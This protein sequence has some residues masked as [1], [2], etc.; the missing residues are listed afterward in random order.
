LMTMHPRTGE[1]SAKSASRTTVWYQ[2]GKFSARVVL[3][4]CL[5]MR[6]RLRVS[7]TGRLG[8]ARF[9]RDP[10]DGRWFR[11]VPGDGSRKSRPATTVLADRGSTQSLRLDDRQRSAA[12]VAQIATPAPPPGARHV[13]P[14]GPENP[15]AFRIGP[16]VAGR[17]LAMAERICAKTARGTAT[18]TLWKITERLCRTMR[19]RS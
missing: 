13:S 8:K 16:A 6:D 9:N 17:S 14:C 1:A 12:K 3:R 18:S 2:A 19:R 5:D 4:A 10:L 15:A 11:R 7:D